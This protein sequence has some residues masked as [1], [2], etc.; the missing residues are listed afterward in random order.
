[1]VEAVR[2]E[3]VLSDWVL[4]RPG[5]LAALL[6]R[7]LWLWVCLRTEA[8]PHHVPPGDTK[9]K[10]Q[11]DQAATKG[12]NANMRTHKERGFT[13]SRSSFLKV[14]YET[15]T[16]FFIETIVH[17]A[18]AWLRHRPSHMTPPPH[19]HAMLRPY[20]APHGTPSEPFIPGAA[21]R[22]KGVRPYR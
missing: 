8:S 21:T 9:I 12:N 1:M 22:A 4:P 19:T 2:R 10:P 15:Q 11:T 18:Q 14:T 17:V 6:L 5:P 13:R 7:R 3:S 16:I 20:A